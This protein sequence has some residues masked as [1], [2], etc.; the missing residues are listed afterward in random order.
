MTGTPEVTVVMATY[1]RGRLILPSVRSV[2]GQSVSGWE[3]RVIGDGDPAGAETGAA[4]AALDDARV[5]FANLPVRCGSQSGPNNAGIAAA[6]GRVVAYLGHDDIWDRDHLARL[7]AL[8]AADPALDVAVSGA[9]YHMPGGSDGALVTG[10]FEGDGAQH[11][12]FFPPSSFAHHRAVTDR[13]GPWRMPQDIVPPV[14]V[15]FL[16]RAA[17]AGLR[18]ASTGQVTVHKFAAGHRYLSYL[19]PDADEQEAMLDAMEAPGHPARVAALVASARAGGRFMIA[20]LPDDAGHAPGEVARRNAA[21]KGAGAMTVSPLG[22]GLTIRPAEE[23]GLF[24][25]HERL[26]H[27]IRWAAGNPAPR[28]AVPVTGPGPARLRL[29]MAH[30][31]R[32]G[33]AQLALSCRG[34]ELRVRPGLMW[35]GGIHWHRHFHTE[36]A[37]S[38]DGPTVLRLHLDPAQV[39][40]PRAR[41][42]G[43]VAMRLR[44][45]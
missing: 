26:R 14:D 7:L 22:E 28:L 16:R 10:M 30:R 13:I 2:L 29:T 20:A 19:D 18:F 25:W 4:L 40:E 27:D 31:R 1:G 15:D 17:Q 44:P 3:L 43:L 39:P 41:A 35:H 24:D 42:I 12:H 36:V 37:L 21:I 34:A 6:R 23:P 32:V 5:T 38:P 45:L 33:L 8:F 9:I 11:A